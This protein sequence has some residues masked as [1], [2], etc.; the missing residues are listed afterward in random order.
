MAGNK[1]NTIV[2]LAIMQPYFFPY[3]GYFQ[4]IH[5]TDRFILYDNLYYIK[6]GWINRNRILEINRG[7]VFWGVNVQTKS[8][9]TKIREIRIDHTTQWQKKVIK[10][11][12]YNY[13]RSRFFNE[14]FP[15]IETT[16]N[17]DYEFLTDL[18]EISIKRVAIFL[19][20]ST[21]IVREHLRYE[22]LEQELALTDYSRVKN[23]EDRKSKRII[24]ICKNEQADIYINLPGGQGLYDK[25]TFAEAKIDLQFIKTLPYSYHQN[26]DTFYSDLSIVDVLM[27]C[28]KEGTKRLLTQYEL[29]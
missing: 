20:I 2:K 16:I 23:G 5:A 24:S 22:T 18:N 4:L 26:A 29:I 7:P 3:L 13:K 9:Y 1:G 8:S 10:Q 27:H 19:D 21:E 14:V 17:E 15:I 6:K 25:K 12:Y 11:V 28:G